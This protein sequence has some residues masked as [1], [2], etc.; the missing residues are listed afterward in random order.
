[1]S[2]RLTALCLITLGC[3]GEGAN[4]LQP[5]SRAEVPGSDEV[6]PIR[7]AVN[8]DLP[9][10]DPHHHLTMIGNA[11]LGNIYEP[12]VCRSRESEIGP[13]LAERW[14]TSD[15][16]T[17]RFFLRPDTHF[18]DASL[19]TIEDVIFSLERAR[20]DPRSEIAGFLAGVE[21][22]VGDAASGSLVVET[23][24]P[25]PFFLESLSMVPIIPASSPEEIT[26]PVGTGP[27]RFVSYQRKDVVRLQGFEDHWR[28]APSEG[29]AEFVVVPDAEEAVD[30]L[31]AGEV[32]LVSYLPPQWVERVQAN[33]DLWVESRLSQSVVYLQ[34]NS[35]IPPF[36]DPRV[37][38][39][40]DL[41]VDREALMRDVTLNH[42]RPASQILG[43]EILGHDPKMEP[44]LRDLGRARKLLESA[45]LD[46]PVA[47][48]IETTSAFLEHARAVASQLE[49]VGFRVE[50]LD[51]PWPEL[52]ADMGKGKVGAW[53][54]IW[55]YDS[56]DGA[57]Y[58]NVV[59]HSPTDDGKLGSSN[60]TF[61]RNPE[62]D[63][64]IRAAS[65]EFD[66]PVREAKLQ[67]VSRRWAAQ[68]VEIP[69]LWPL[70]LYGTR[71]DL[72]WE[73]RKDSALLLFDMKRGD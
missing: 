53:L 70:D 42:T 29:A 24:Q 8:E 43:P 28:G 68:R 62:L 44:T 52:Y 34:L 26:E 17:W 55:G 57:A 63:G 21:S 38:E 18:H 16:K 69:L 60:Q 61:Y 37:R 5:E 11:V 23:A 72:E 12:L 19:L 1:M 32:D 49:E 25:D 9:T 59:V 64:L 46:L 14:E 45:P 35:G 15:S 10:L 48:T 41:T 67:E 51:R 30:L 4:P 40:I 36:D 58:F 7:L 33:D 54:G 6:R 20:N 2:L 39:A 27:Y 71:R 56:S 47:L 31:D 50:V 22:I 66:L 13:C 3:Q 73:A 65:A